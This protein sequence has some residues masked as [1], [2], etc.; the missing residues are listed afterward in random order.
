MIAYQ[1][2]DFKN[3]FL[4]KR[5]YI[6]EFDSDKLWIYYTLKRMRSK[7]VIII[8]ILSLAIYA[9]TL[10]NGFV[11]DDGLVIV[12][13][14]FIKDINNIPRLFTSS[15]FAISGEMSYRPVVTLSYFL[16]YAA[17]GGNPRWYHFVN[18]SLHAVNGALLYLFIANV[19][20]P[21]LT[22]RQGSNV[23]HNQALA[24]SLLFA[25]HPVL[26][27][28]VNA[29][30]YREDL[31]AFLFYIA[32][33][34]I[35]IQ[36][37][38]NYLSLQSRFPYIAFLVTYL[39]AL[40]SKEMALTLPLVL[41]IYEWMFLYSKKGGLLGIFLNRYV[42][43]CGGITLAYLWLRFY[44]FRSPIEEALQTWTFSE[45][46]ST[47]PWLLIN[48]F[49][50]ILF[51]LSLSADHEISAIRPLHS[52]ASWFAV[53]MVFV[54]VTLFAMR[55]G[56]KDAAF[57]A[58]YFTVAVL[59]ICNI[60]PIANPFAERYMYLPLVGG[61]IFVVSVA[62]F[63]ME[64]LSLRYNILRPLFV[65]VFILYAVLAVERNFIWKDK[66]SLWTD[67]VKKAPD[68]GR[69]HNNLGEAYFN[70]GYLDKAELE[71]AAAVRLKSD[72]VVFYHN[73]GQVYYKQGRLDKAIM[74]Y[75]KILKLSPGY[76]KAHFDLGN[77]Y[78]EKDRL[79]E[80][81]WEFKQ[82]IKYKP[83]H[84]D[85]HIHLGNVYF[86]QGYLDS[87]IEKYKDALKFNPGHALVHYN[88]GLIFNKKGAKDRAR[89]EFEQAF[90]SDPK[91]A[92]AGLA[93]E[94]LGNIP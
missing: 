22:S 47:V 64:D 40:F 61:I 12:K 75:K 32:A 62:R 4:E 25:A 87:A 31:L 27:E 15:Y 84:I 43:G 86:I 94:S 66:Y 7:P 78:A 76:A 52:L 58:L 60:V 16:D 83:D 18:I 44:Y 93:I 5:E 89:E 55:K 38:S 34:N 23:F 53:I 77:V 21:A 79:D 45:R 48:Y 42:A 71:F 54:V 91:L 39:L 57:G 1:Y 28:A 29:I 35:Y 6:I 81:A 30:S 50:I 24:V 80:A 3:P 8:I 26:T 17:F 73:L 65:V 67:T 68:S 85:A 82:T 92:E 33:L 90:K 11:Y 37:R 2:A 13:N 46:L 56:R 36:A 69:A 74:E 59:P 20:R 51:P 88:L 70:M 41:I 72:D 63:L 14:E 19:F 10:N 9:N 49:K